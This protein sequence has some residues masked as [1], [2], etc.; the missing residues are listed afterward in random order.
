MA[1]ETPVDVF[2]RI[3]ARIDSGE[4]SVAKVM[5]TI[6]S[7]DGPEHRMQIID[8]MIRRF[9]NALA[10]YK[11]VEPPTEECAQIK[12]RMQQ[13]TEEILEMLVALYVK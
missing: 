8:E 11:H 4:F 6:E 5:E 3:Q 2:V 7:A 10:S 9:I 1:K 13:V 12:R